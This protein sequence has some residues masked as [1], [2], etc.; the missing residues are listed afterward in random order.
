M[1]LKKQMSE[2]FRLGAILA[3]VGGFLDAYTYI[4]RGGVFANAQTG[5]I[6]LLGLS[7]AEGKGWEAITYS[8]PIIAFAVGVMIAEYIRNTFKKRPHVH[9]RQVIIALEFFILLTVAFLPMGK[10]NTFVNILISFICSMQVEGF[11]KINGNAVATTMCTGN[12]RSGT[13]LLFQYIQTKEK[14]LKQRCVQYY[15]IILFFIV[16]AVAGTYFSKL[17]AE[18]AVLLCCF[19]LAIAF[20]MMFLEGEDSL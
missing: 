7:I 12:L 1:Y 11:R 3:I 13:E 5:N 16:G 10:W 19:L 6:V 14:I 18:A 17:L 2:T 8:F 9:W 15:G 4:L 20:V